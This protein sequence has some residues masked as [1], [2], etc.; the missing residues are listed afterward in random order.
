MSRGFSLVEVLVAIVVAAVLSVPILI[1]TTSS[2]TETCKAIN[3][4]RAL[5]IA[6]ETVEWISATPLTAKAIEELKACEG[7]LQSYPTG[8]N[9]LWPSLKDITYPGQYSP[10]FFFRKIEIEPVSDSA[11]DYRDYLHKVV[12]TVL[13]SE[14]KTP[15]N[16]ADA[17]REKKIVLTTLVFD[18]GRGY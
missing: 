1:L 3:Y 18:E 8:A 9:P 7:S 10:A 6:H 14:G 5:E 17:D 15:V 2:R 4:L 12:V 16:S 13:W 11:V